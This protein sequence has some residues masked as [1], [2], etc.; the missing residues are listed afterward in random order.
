MRLAGSDRDPESTRPGD[1][2]GA[3]PR[4]A[5]EASL[6]APHDGAIARAIATEEKLHFKLGLIYSDQPTERLEELYDAGR[7]APLAHAPEIDRELF[8]RSHT[9][10]MMGVDG[11]SVSGS[12]PRP[13]PGDRMR[14]DTQVP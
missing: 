13:E 11:G 10:P 8:G 7:I 1:R 12:S 3:K 9:V 2:P 14:L 4:A 5:A 6:R